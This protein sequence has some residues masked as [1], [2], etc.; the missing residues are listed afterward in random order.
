[1]ENIRDF[2]NLLSM[3]AKYKKYNGKEDLETLTDLQFMALIYSLDRGAYGINKVGVEPF[4]QQLMIDSTYENRGIGWA[5]DIE[6]NLWY[7][8]Q[9]FIDCLPYP[10]VRKKFKYDNIEL[11]I[12]VRME[13]YMNARLPMAMTRVIAPNGGSIPIQLRHKQ[14]LKSIVSETIDLLDSFKERGSNVIEELTKEIVL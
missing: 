3:V 4:V 7:T 5:L 8:K 6:R 12:V 10:K 1:M 14:T 13:S 11:K 9:A 2:N